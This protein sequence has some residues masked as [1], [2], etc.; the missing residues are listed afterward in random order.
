MWGETNHTV[1]EGYR[2][3]EEGRQRDRDA[4]TPIAVKCLRHQEMSHSVER[5]G[6]RGGGLNHEIDGECIFPGS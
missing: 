5:R 2:Y 6:R 1:W 4:H 3:G